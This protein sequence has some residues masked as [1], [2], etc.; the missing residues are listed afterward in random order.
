MT[1]LPCQTKE[2]G[3]LIEGHHNAAICRR[4]TSTR[5]G[6]NINP[7]HLSNSEEDVRSEGDVNMCCDGVST[8]CPHRKKH[9]C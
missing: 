1:I 9:S 7:L 2:N 6:M 5:C 8:K 4:K 3:Y